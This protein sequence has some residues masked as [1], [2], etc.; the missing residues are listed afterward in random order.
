MESAQHGGRHHPRRCRC[1]CA[2]HRAGLRVGDRGALCQEPAAERGAQGRPR[3]LLQPHG[4][5]GIAGG[6]GSPPRGRTGQSASQ[7]QCPP[8]SDRPLPRE[9]E[10]LSCS[11]PE[12]RPA[13]MGGN[14]R[15]A[16]EEVNPFRPSDRLP[17]PSPC[18]KVRPPTATPLLGPPRK[19]KRGG[20]IRFVAAQMGAALRGIPRRYQKGG[21]FFA[22]G[23]G[24][25]Q[26]DA[27]PR[28][29]LPATRPHARQKR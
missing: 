5:I 2:K 16:V 23:E 28:A 14:L 8:P 22:G 21:V 19:K 17:S 1:G 7:C 3:N 9:P 27:V 24:R 12:I 29:Q 25:P 10:A 26:C 18:P 6:P 20:S 4:R 11:T 15:G 13:N